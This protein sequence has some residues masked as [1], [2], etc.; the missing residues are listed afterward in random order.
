MS[1][2]KKL[3]STATVVG[4]QIQALTCTSGTGPSEKPTKH[5]FTNKTKGVPKNTHMSH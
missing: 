2:L 5:E 4:A 1:N 3:I